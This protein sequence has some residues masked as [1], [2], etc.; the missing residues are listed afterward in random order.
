MV[1]TACSMSCFVGDGLNLD[2][3]DDLA[4]S[5]IIMP[6]RKVP[7][8]MLKPKSNP[9]VRKLPAKTLARIR[10]VSATALPVR[11][12]KGMRWIKLLMMNS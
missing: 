10:L 2:D 3:N 4:F 9:S 8:M 11:R 7:I 5:A 1:L 6:T 12:R